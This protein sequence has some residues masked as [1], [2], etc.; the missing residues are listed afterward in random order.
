VEKTKE[1]KGSRGALQK[2]TRGEEKIEQRRL[3]TLKPSMTNREG[4]EG[5]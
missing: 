4:E 2:K 1:S 5:R 3:E